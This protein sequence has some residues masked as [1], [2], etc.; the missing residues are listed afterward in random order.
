MD[1]RSRP[2][3]HA[4]V[5][6]KDIMCQAVESSP[7]DERHPLQNL[8]YFLVPLFLVPAFLPVRK[9]SADPLTSDCQTFPEFS[10]FT[11]MRIKIT[12]PTT[13][14]TTTV[15]FFLLSVSAER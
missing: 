8:V 1:R 4:H 15:P 11:E 13:P 12:R 5:A 10:A 9:E 2:L 14:T 3:I 6:S 7:D